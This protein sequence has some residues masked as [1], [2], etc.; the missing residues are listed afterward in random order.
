MIYGIIRLELDEFSGL[1]TRWVPDLE[2]VRF[3][4]Q[5]ADRDLALEELEDACESYEDYAP[6]DSS[7]VTHVEFISDRYGLNRMKSVPRP[8]G[9]RGKFIKKSEI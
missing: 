6:I 9:E 8:R 7:P 2:S 5:R 1:N 3:Y 4:S